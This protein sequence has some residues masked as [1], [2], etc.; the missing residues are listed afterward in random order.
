MLNKIISTQLEIVVSGG[1]L[2]DTDKALIKKASATTSDELIKR[3]NDTQKKLG[4]GEIASLCFAVFPFETFGEN[5]NGDSVFEKPFGGIIGENQTLP[6][7]TPSYMKSG[8]VYENHNSSNTDNKIGD[9]HYA[10][11]NE[12][13]HRV[14]LIMS[15]KRSAAP[16]IYRKFK[17]KMSVLVSMGCKVQYDVCSV[18]KNIATK[19]SEHCDHV[20]YQLLDFVN[21][22][23]VH[24]IN[25]GM[26]YFDI[27]TVVING[28][29]NARVAYVAK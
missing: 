20:K 25:A 9:V 6:A 28:D 12:E 4:E 19:P 7:A 8:K 13:Q 23:P 2:S 26:T 29:I 21:G 1:N 5:D 27:S 11:Y 16:H 10:N 24:M 15:V 3:V 17:N 14:E 22:I 18:C